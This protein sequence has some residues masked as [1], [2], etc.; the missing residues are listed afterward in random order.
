MQSLAYINF[1]TPSKSSQAPSISHAL[2]TKL[3]EGHMPFVKTNEIVLM[4]P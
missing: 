3:L 1:L 2:K 4:Y